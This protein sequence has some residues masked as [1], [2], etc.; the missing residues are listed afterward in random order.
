MPT[1]PD[2]ARGLLLTIL[3][4]FVLPGG[5]PVWTSAFVAALDRLGVEEAAARQA[6]ARTADHG[7]LASER[8]GRRTRWQLTDRAVRLLR[9][10]TER[11]YTFGLNQRPWSGVWLLLVVP[12]V[13]EADRPLRH[14]LRQR[15]GWAGF[16]PLVSGLWV[17]PWPDREREAFEVLDTLG[18]AEGAHSFAARPGAIGD[19]RGLVLEAWDLGALD[20]DYQAFVAGLR[21]A[22]PI[23]DEARF[24]ALSLLV[25]DWRRFPA[26]D[27]GL[28]DELLPHRWH[29][30][31]AAARFHELHDRWAPAA[32]LWWASVAVDH[33]PRRSIGQ[34]SSTSSPSTR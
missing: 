24:T 10:G 28:P 13:S 6:I 1:R 32:Q 11:I 5:R 3:G 29:G 23:G 9:D 18:V 16:S 25:H 8:V 17:C 12:P 30:Q 33:Q 19:G 31:A 20:A 14:R 22:R 15:L 21:R 2:G 27:P 7:L 34:T 26:D 4:E